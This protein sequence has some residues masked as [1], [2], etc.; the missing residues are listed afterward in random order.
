[1]GRTKALACLIAALA[2]GCSNRSGRAIVVGSK[3][4]T[5]QLVLGE[6]AAQQIE[7]R[8]HTKVVRRLNLGGTLLTQQAL[9][10][11]EIDLYPEYTGTAYSAILKLPLGA[12]RAGIAGR[13]RDEYRSRFRLEWFAPLGFANG[14]AIA[15]RGPEAR[16]HKLATLSDAA[17]YQ[18]GW[19]M[20]VGYEFLQRPD[21]YP[22]LMK[23]YDLPVSG[24]PKTMDLG[25]V[26]RALESGQVNMAAGSETD[27]LLAALD[28]KVLH[29]DRGAFPPYDAAFVAR[30]AAL[31]AHPGLRE[32]VAELSGKLDEKTMQELNRQV[33]YNHR[34]VEAVARAFLER[35]GLTRPAQR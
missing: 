6:I 3:N 29:D 2:A 19:Q 7:N 9:L 12:D 27:G 33:D 17:R 30:P 28:V 26:Y 23:T 5:E 14:F 31:A 16:A 13:V 15:V 25:L 35:A 32:A 8:L 10:T 20:G 21:G 18:P 4:F 11:G 24:A 1:M 22:A 34:P